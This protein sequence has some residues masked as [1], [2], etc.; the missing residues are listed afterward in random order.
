M[1]TH[2]VQNGGVVIDG[3]KSIIYYN[4]S[5][6]TF[7]YPYIGIYYSGGGAKYGKGHILADSY[8]GDPVNFIILK[9]QVNIMKIVQ[10]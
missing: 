10:P 5:N 4:S 8:T 3:T 1:L 7:E 2:K 9:I 6:Q